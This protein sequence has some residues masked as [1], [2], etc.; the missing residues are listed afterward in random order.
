MR[1]TNFVVRYAKNEAPAEPVAPLHELLAKLIP[2][3]F[4]AGPPEPDKLL[5]EREANEAVGGNLPGL[6]A[7]GFVVLTGAG[8]RLSSR[9]VEHLARTLAHAALNRSALHGAGRTTTGDAVVSA[10]PTPGARL[11]PARTVRTWYHAGGPQHTPLATGHKRYRSPPKRASVATAVLLDCS[12]SMIL[13]GEDRF[14]PAKHMALALAG[15]VRRD[16]PTDELHFITFH[17][18]ATVVHEN[19][20][21]M[22]RIGP[23]YT[24]TAAGLALARQVLR[25][26]RARGKRVV[27][28]TDGKP[29]MITLP[30]GNTYQNSYGIDPQIRRA[31]LQAAAAC[32]HDG[33]AFTSVMIAKDPLLRAF[34]A[35]FNRVTRGTLHE[36]A[37]HELLNVLLMWRDE[38][39]TFANQA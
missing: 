13:Y 10:A 4:R 11:L 27:L 20:L 23:W 2:S 22:Q 31:T 14:T 33:I 30:S 3:G 34:M 38:R 5:S 35:D 36:L 39:V 17:N 37:P 25:R 21:A 32:V 7:A 1:L 18:S 28:I 6:V 9:G 15:L 16:F 26:S 19:D 24:N 29:S 8:V 12:H